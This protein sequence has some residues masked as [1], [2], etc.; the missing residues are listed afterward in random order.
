MGIGNN[1]ANT[2]VRYFAKPLDFW[3]MVYLTQFFNVESVSAPY[4]FQDRLD[5]TRLQ[6]SACFQYNGNAFRIIQ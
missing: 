5:T 3:L 2:F 1:L 4:N 6:K